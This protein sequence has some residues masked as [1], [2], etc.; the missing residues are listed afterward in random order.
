MNLDKLC[1]SASKHGRAACAKR[2]IKKK[3]TTTNVYEISEPFMLT[4]WKYANE[5]FLH[6]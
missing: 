4:L 3:Q 5:E 1:H 2:E 6:K